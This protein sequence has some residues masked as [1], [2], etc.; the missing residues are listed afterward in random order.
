VML[1]PKLSRATSTSTVHRITRAA[2]PSILA[3]VCLVRSSA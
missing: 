3:T 2:S 1:T